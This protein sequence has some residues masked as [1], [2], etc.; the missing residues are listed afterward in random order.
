[1]L[2]ATPVLGITFVLLFPAIIIGTCI[3]AIAKDI[4]KIFSI[5]GGVTHLAIS[6]WDPAVAYFNKTDESSLPGEQTTNLEGLK[7][8]VLEKKELE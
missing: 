7:K 5:R 1:M 3:F 8:E 2:L 4:A 6:K